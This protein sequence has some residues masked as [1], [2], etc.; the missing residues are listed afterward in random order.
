MSYEQKMSNPETGRMFDEYARLIRE[1][2]EIPNAMLPERFRDG[3]VVYGGPSLQELENK[4]KQ[5]EDTESE[6]RKLK[7]E[8][9]ERAEEYRKQWEANPDSP[10]TYNENEHMLYAAQMRFVERAVET[11]MIEFDDKF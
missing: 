6:Y 8:K 5:E 4:I 2:I 10:L 11:G 1:T 9:A 7:R 3:R